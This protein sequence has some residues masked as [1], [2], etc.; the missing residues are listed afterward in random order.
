MTAP[1]HIVAVAGFFT[2]DEGKILLVKTPH[3]GWEC[4]GGQVELG[5]DLL[6]ALER[7]VD[8][9]SSC[10]VRV[11]R[12][13]GVYTNPASHPKVMFM[14]RGTYVS[15]TPQANN[16]TLDAGWFSA[17]EA[18]AIVDFPANLN[19]LRDALANSDRPIYRVYIARPYEVLKET[20][21]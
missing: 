12:L 2:N 13:V 20:R 21:V 18:L 3:R 7:E 14:F 17:E 6:Q 15:G 8:E 16:E 4:P 5:E 1:R 9:E 10:Q 19:K 11:E